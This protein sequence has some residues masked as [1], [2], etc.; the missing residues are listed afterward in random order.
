M[1]LERSLASRWT[2]WCLSL[3]EVVN[4]SKHCYNRLAN[5]YA[6]IIL[7]YWEYSTLCKILLHLLFATQTYLCKLT[8]VFA[9]ML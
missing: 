1:W 7:L 6:M 2:C 8:Q 4:I 3:V 9:A 5:P